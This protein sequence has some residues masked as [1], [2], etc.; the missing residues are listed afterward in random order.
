MRN[1]PGECC[2]YRILDRP[3]ALE[4]G[5]LNA[6]DKDNLRTQHG[7][8]NIDVVAPKSLFWG[9]DGSAAELTN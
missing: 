7:V 5:R 2:D 6:S 1:E 4:S 9:T 3:L 8:F